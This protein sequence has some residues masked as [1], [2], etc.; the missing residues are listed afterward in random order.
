MAT[1]GAEISDP[2]PDA[3]DAD[4]EGSLTR[5]KSRQQYFI[6]CNKCVYNIEVQANLDNL[7]KL[8]ILSYSYL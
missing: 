2:E 6:Y 7:I 3:L 4:V 8:I 1:T 5:L